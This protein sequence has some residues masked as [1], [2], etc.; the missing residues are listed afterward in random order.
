MKSNI[1]FSHE[2]MDSSSA[3]SKYDRCVFA[4]RNSMLDNKEKLKYKLVFGH[5]KLL[6]I[7]NKILLIVFTS[8]NHYPW[9]QSVFTIIPAD[10]ENNV[11][12]SLRSCNSYINI[13]KNNIAWHDSIKLDE[14]ENHIK[15][16][17]Y[18]YKA[19]LSF[20]KNNELRLFFKNV[21]IANSR[22]SS[23]VTTE[24]SSWDEISKDEISDFIVKFLL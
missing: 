9:S 12:S 7:T 1:S 5:W 2:S 13:T 15:I 20:K 11:C 18:V 19:K 16:A 4:D 22:I 14:L 17:R 10:Y 23:L 24:I 6:K 8:Q 3:D 21:P